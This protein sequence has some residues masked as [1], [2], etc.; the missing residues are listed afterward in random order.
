MHLFLSN[1]D[2]LNL[3]THLYIAYRVVKLA[4][5]NSKDILYRSDYYKRLLKSKFHEKVVR[6]STVDGCID[7]LN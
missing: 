7:K 1:H 5:G 6:T 4:A 3:L 2:S